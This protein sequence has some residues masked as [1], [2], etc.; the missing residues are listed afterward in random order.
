MHFICIPDVATL[1]SRQDLAINCSCM[2][3]NTICNFRWNNY[4]GFFWDVMP[5][6]VLKMCQC[7]GGKCFLHLLFSR[8]MKKECSVSLYPVDL[9]FLRCDCQWNC[10]S[11][12]TVAHPRTLVYLQQQDC[13]NIKLCISM[14]HSHFVRSIP[15][16]L[17]ISSPS[18]YTNCQ[19]IK[20][21]ISWCELITF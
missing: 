11:S 8:D 21:I 12:D 19:R 4:R 18:D 16:F 15:S 14:T 10:S 3:L 5:C 7:L 6:C 20:W 9:S 1:C 13:A 2:F 17:L